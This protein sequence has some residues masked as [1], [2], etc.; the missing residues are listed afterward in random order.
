MAVLTR[1][2][3]VL[4]KRQNGNT[5]T[6]NTGANSASD[7]AA[8]LAHT[9]PPEST[10]TSGVTGSST[11]GLSPGAIAGT[12]VGAGFALGLLALGAFFIGQRYPRAG[13]GRDRN[14]GLKA[15][16]KG[17]NSYQN[18]PL[19]DRRPYMA[20]VLGDTGAHEMPHNGGVYVHELPGK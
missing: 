14:D 16:P 17:H 2:R 19:H 20:E 11:G 4:I 3:W 13:T 12:V 7:T 1:V 18:L 15:D 9:A 6:A 10:K 8:L 5:N